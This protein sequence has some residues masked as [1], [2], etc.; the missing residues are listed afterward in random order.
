MRACRRNRASRCPDCPSHRC[1]SW[2]SI[3]RTRP[4]RPIFPRQN[5]RNRVSRRYRHPCHS[6]FARPTRPSC[7]LWYPPTSWCPTNR[8]I[9]R[10]S[11]SYCAQRTCS[12]SSRLT[13][14][15]TRSRPLWRPCRSPIWIHIPPTTNLS[16]STSRRCRIRTIHRTRSLPPP[17][18][19]CSSH[20]PNGWKNS[21]SC[22]T[23]SPGPTCRNRHHPSHSNRTIRTAC[24]STWTCFPS[25]RSTRWI[26]CRSSSLGCLPRPPRST[27]LRPVST[28]PS[29]SA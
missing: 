28:L 6:N 22:S 24:R 8:T 4:F 5:R 14:C 11:D 10:S 9:A 17:S 1:G 12:W 7:R 18:S 13:N 2:T 15:R 19:T 16:R 25:R 3:A 20:R 23:T 21:N 26:V 27:R 29:R